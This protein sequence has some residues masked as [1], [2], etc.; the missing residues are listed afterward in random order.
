MS[1]SAKPIAAPMENC[2]VRIGV[3]GDRSCVELARVSHCRNCEVYAAGGRRLF[4]RA[5]PAEYLESWT[6]L[7]EQDRGAGEAK[8]VP[9]LVFRIGQVWLAFAATSLREITDPRVIR[10]V[11]HRPP[12]TLLGLVNVRGELY[13]CVS[14]HALFDEQAIVPRP[15]TARFFVARWPSGDWVFPVD[16]VMG[17]HEVTEDKV[18]TL[19]MT[20]K[21]V[22]AVYTRGLFRQADK[23][24]AIIDDSLLFPALER[25]LG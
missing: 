1:D 13:P 3:W 2:W 12:E 9:H 20:L 7:L 24:V 22:G 10:R 19:P 25:R 21:N 14:L 18:E 17:M 5:V 6:V 11:P 15:R 4:D 23:T 8:S 16:E